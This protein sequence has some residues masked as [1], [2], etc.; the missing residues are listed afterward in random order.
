MMSKMNDRR[1]GIHMRFDE[2]GLR[3]RSLCVT[4]ANRGGR[5]PQMLTLVYS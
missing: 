1:L 3:K 2:P 5:Q 4:V